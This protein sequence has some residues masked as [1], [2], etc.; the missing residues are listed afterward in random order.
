MATLATFSSL[1][2]DQAI[3]ERFAY[4]FWNNRL[5]EE[6]KK[7][8]LDFLFFPRDSDALASLPF[9]FGPRTQ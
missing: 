9:P 6:R 3:K 4:S 1:R 8:G 5:G 2:Q 7:K